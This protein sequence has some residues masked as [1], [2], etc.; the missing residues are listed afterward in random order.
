[1]ALTPVSDGAAISRILQGYV[2]VLY[3]LVTKV[4]NGT[5]L[6]QSI[7]ELSTGLPYYNT[8]SFPEAS[9]TE[10]ADKKQREGMTLVFH[11]FIISSC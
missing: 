9:I 4:G 1:M 8:A 5:S 6:S 3:E 11:N 10:N 7:W 2:H